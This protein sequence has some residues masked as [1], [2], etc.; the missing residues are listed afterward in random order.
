[1]TVV[2]VRTVHIRGPSRS[3]LGVSLVKVGTEIFQIL[4]VIIQKTLFIQTTVEIQSGFPND[5][6]QPIR[7]HQFSANQSALE[8]EFESLVKIMI[9]VDHGVI[10]IVSRLKNMRDMDIVIFQNV[11]TSKIKDEDKLHALPNLPIIKD[12]DIK[13]DR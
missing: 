4:L 9:L 7:A 1:M 5:F 6:S 10:Q 11:Q 13:T 2:G 12:R 8:N 3:K